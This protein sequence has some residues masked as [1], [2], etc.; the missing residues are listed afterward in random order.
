VNP[1]FVDSFYF[2]AVLNP[3]D[4]A[5]KRAMEFSSR[6]S[7]PLVTTPWILTEVADGLARSANRDLVR[8]LLVNVRANP[9][10]QLIAASD[11]LFE[12]GVE[13]YDSRP[14]EQWS[15]TDCIS[16]VVMS[17]RGIQE[18]LTGDRHYEQAGFTAL[19]KQS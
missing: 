4:A 14:D 2:F 3:G 6:F 11:E 8:R 16:F 18:A 19:L 13:L 15:L 9:V 17:E 7:P 12:K 1:V 10:N 5:H